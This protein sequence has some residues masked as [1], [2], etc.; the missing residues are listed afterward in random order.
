MVGSQFFVTL[1]EDTDYLDSEHLVIGELVGDWETMVERLNGV[2]TD[3]QHR[4]YQVGHLT[5]PH[6]STS[7]LTSPHLLSPHLTSFHRTSPPHP[8]SPHLTPRTCV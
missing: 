6:P 3:K 5:P 8:T 7:H 1:G 2:I 4:P